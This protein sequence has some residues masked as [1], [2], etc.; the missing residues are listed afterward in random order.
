MDARDLPGAVRYEGVH[1]GDIVFKVG[2]EY[3]ASCGAKRDPRTIVFKIDRQ[4]TTDLLARDPRFKRYTYEKS[5]LTI[6]AS[7]VDDW[8]QMKA[9][10]EESYR[11]AAAPKKSTPKKSTP[12]KPKR[13]SAKGG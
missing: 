12:K 10:V 1:Y 4:R 6:D 5:A 7:D 13:T 2:K 8:Q 11:L 3:F 9:L